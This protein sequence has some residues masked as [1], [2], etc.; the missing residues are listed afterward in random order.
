MKSRTLYVPSNVSL[1]NEVWKGL[2]VRDGAAVLGITL[3]AA[4]LA[5][6]LGLVFGVPQLWCVLFVLIAAG[7]GVAVLTK[8]DT[9]LSMVDYIGISLKFAKEQKRFLYIYRR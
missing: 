1:R 8:F 3:A 9:N 5:A 4:G 2:S 6:M 7:I